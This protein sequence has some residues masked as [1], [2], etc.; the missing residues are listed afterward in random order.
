MGM[1]TRKKLECALLGRDITASYCYKVIAV[2]LMRMVL[3][4]TLDDPIED[5]DAAFDVCD[6]CQYADGSG[7]DD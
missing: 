7:F 5:L 4:C 3:P 2:V 1:K 6:A